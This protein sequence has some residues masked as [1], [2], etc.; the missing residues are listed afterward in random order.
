MSHVAITTSASVAP[1]RKKVPNSTS[2]TRLKAA[3]LDD[4]LAA[5]GPTAISSSIDETA[6][7]SIISELKGSCAISPP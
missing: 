1:A 5:S 3:G 4:H 2:G 7:P 6:A